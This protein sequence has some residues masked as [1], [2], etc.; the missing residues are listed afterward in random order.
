[1]R[2]SGTVV[3]LFAA[4]IVV[5]L[6]IS[7]FVIHEVFVSELSSFVE[8]TGGMYVL[9]PE[10]AYN[11]A[12]TIPNGDL[13]RWLNKESLH[14]SASWIYWTIWPSVFFPICMIIVIMMMLLRFETAFVISSI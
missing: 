12:Q 9:S 1:M 2:K 8:Q 5:C 11:L 7:S 13:S 14:Q 6:L 4:A 10:D 3:L